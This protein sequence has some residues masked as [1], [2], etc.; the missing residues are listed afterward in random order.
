MGPLAERAG[1]TW[2]ADSPSDP[3]R[4]GPR[5]RRAHHRARRRRPPSG[6]LR[7][8]PVG[9]RRVPAGAGLPLD[10]RQTGPPPGAVPDAR[11]GGG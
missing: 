8:E 4:A 1:G 11:R 3:F 6:A 2:P 10:A 5:S 9:R 7:I